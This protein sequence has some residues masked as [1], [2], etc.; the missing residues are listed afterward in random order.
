MRRN[1]IITDQFGDMKSVFL[2]TFHQAVLHAR[3]HLK[4]KAKNS[5][6]TSLSVDGKIMLKTRTNIDIMTHS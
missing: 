1:T 2:G 5:M 6:L 4:E 3:Y